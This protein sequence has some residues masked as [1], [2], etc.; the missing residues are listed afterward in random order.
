MTLG[1]LEAELLEMNANSE[2]LQ[3][4]YNELIEFK[5]VL[6][7]VSSF[8]TAML[9]LVNLSDSGDAKYIDLHMQCA[10]ICFMLT[11][12]LPMNCTLSTF[13]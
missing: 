5:L 8:S 13:H 2:K 7:K 4:T 3:H 9:I 10:E 11:S 6:L 12:R 1:E